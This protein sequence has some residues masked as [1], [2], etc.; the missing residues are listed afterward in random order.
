MRVNE[1]RGEVVN[2]GPGTMALPFFAIRT[3]LEGTA[4]LM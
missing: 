3:R 4:F 1:K 2:N